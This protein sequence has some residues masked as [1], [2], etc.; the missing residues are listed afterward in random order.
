MSQTIPKG[1]KTA[2]TR[3]VL[4]VQGG[5]A[6][7]NAIAPLE[8][9]AA[10]NVS[11]YLTQFNQTADQ[12]AIQDRRYC[13]SQVFEIPGE[14]TKSLQVS[15]TF[16]LDSLADDAARIALT[17]GTRGT[18]IRFLQKDEDDT[19]FDAG[20][21]YDAVDVECGEQIVIDGE[22]N[23]LDRIQQKMFIQSEWAAFKQLGG[24]GKT[25]WTVTIGGAPTGG[26]FTLS[27]NGAATAPIAHNATAANVVAALN[28]LSGVT[29]VSGITGTGSAGGPHSITL[30]TAGVISGNGSGLTGGTAPSVS[31]A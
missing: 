30:P 18:L 1:I 3:R 22:E 20:D 2:G 19:T 16:N 13:S 25:G 24:S 4:F 29:G 6:D 26:T 10:K 14:K 23:A 21:W 15:Y 31:V 8:A 5:V 7:K 28:A 17:E 11:C 27:L 9:A 12:A